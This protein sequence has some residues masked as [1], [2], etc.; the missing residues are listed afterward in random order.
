MLAW[1]EV[2]AQTLNKE[3]AYERVNVPL[4]EPM[5]NR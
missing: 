1:L 5:E 2:L 3:N 4:L